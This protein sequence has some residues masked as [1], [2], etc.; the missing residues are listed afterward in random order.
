VAIKVLRKTEERV[1]IIVSEPNHPWV[2]GVENLFTL[3]FLPLVR[4]RVSADGVYCQ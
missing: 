2:A 1:D 4:D 3:V